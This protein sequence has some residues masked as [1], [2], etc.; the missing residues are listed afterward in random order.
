MPLKNVDYISK[1]QNSLY[2]KVIVFSFR[3]VISHVFLCLSL[4]NSPW[5]VLN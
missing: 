5:N 3:S 1:A 4:K 2:K